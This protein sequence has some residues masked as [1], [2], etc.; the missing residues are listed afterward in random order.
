MWLELG[1]S[2]PV[3]EQNIDNIA[4]ISAILSFFRGPDIFLTIQGVFVI[5]SRYYRNIAILSFMKWS[6][7]RRTPELLQLRP[8]VKQHPRLRSR[9]ENEIEDEMNVFI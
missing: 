8:T 9:Y 4:D 7:R 6:F 1:G 3:K 2:L 5:I